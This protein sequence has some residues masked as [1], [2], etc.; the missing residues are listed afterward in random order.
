MKLDLRITQLRL[1]VLIVSFVAFP[2]IGLAECDKADPPIDCRNAETAVLRINVESSQGN[3]DNDSVAAARQRFWATYPDA[4]G[5]EEARKRFAEA[6][7]QKDLRNL[8]LFSYPNEKLQA[9]YGPEAI[10]N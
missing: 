9:R 6:L 1:A 4:A 10:G 3:V 8:F 5:H 2:K 7:Y